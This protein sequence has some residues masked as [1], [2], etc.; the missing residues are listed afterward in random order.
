MQA[1]VVY[2]SEKGFS[3]I[4]LLRVQCMYFLILFTVEVFKKILRVLKRT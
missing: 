2:E 1:V 4:F 3:N